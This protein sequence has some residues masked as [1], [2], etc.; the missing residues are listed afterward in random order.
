MLVTTK[1]VLKFEKLLCGITITSEDNEHFRK[2]RKVIKNSI[3]NSSQL[4]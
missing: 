2:M 3:E 1:K 4:C